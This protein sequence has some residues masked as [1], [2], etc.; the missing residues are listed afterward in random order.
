MYKYSD[1]K[2]AKQSKNESNRDL[3]IKISTWDFNTIKFSSV[4]KLNEIDLF[5]KNVQGVYVIFSKLNDEL[6]FSYVGISNNI[7]TRLKTHKSNIEKGVDRT[8]KPWL[9]LLNKNNQNIDD[10]YFGIILISDNEQERFKFEIINIM[11]VWN[12][13]TNVNKRLRDR[14]Y[15]CINCG[16]GMINATYVSSPDKEIPYSIKIKC[17]RKH[18]KKKY[19]LI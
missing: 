14:K 19:M 17:I 9:K 11:K 1:I 8:Y 10:L 4:S 12:K 5:E 3:A 18:C 6:S 13:F 2:I 16:G 15:H 7:R